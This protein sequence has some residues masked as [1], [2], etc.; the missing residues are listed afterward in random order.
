LQPKHRGIDQPELA[1]EAVVEFHRHVRR[2][3]EGARIVGVQAV[4]KAVAR[5]QEGGP[6]RFD[7]L[8]ELVHLGQVDGPGLEVGFQQAQHAELRAET[9]LGVADLLELLEESDEAA[10]GPGAASD[11]SGTGPPPPSCLHRRS[12]P[13]SQ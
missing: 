7:V 5:L 3:P 9:V 4:L 11:E 13:R 8:A 2:E 6:L 1:D 10:Y 12:S